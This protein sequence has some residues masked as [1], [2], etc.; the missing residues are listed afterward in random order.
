MRMLRQTIRGCFT[1]PHVGAH[2][3]NFWLW[4]F[5]AMGALAGAKGGFPGVLFG[6][7]VMLI[8]MGI[9]YLFGAYGRA[10]E[11]DSSISAQQHKGEA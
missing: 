5:V 8:G 9:P 6:A 3:G 11:S 2:P 4:A 10:Q 7:L 1:L